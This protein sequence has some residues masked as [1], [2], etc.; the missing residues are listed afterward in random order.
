MK[1]FK[2]LLLVI[3][4]FY[5]GCA[6]SSTSQTP[7]APPPGC[8]KAYFYNQGK[9]FL[10]YGPALLRAGIATAMLAEPKSELP[11]RTTAIA[12]WAIFKADKLDLVMAQRVVE[13][14]VKEAKYARPALIAFSDLIEKVSPIG[15]GGTLTACDKDIILSLIKNIGVDA[16]ANPDL[17][18]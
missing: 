18:K 6:T 12:F 9:A 14:Q 3:T 11:V 17:F 4:L 8:E 16:G 7:S 2:I 5:F 13:A 15:Q 10:P 1:L